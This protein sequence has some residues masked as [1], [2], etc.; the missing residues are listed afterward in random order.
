MGSDQLSLLAFSI[1]SRINRIAEALAGIELF[2]R[3]A[4]KAAAEGIADLIKK[5]IPVW[6]G[7]L[8]DSVEVQELSP[9]AYAVGPTL[10]YGP[11]VNF[12]TGPH[13]P[14]MDKITEWGNAHGFDPSAL[15]S[16]IESFGT[17]AHP[18]MET[19]AAE[20]EGMGASLFFDKISFSLVGGPGSFA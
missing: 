18:F 13:L 6:T 7:D 20:A 10:Y 3:E 5:N 19:A 16:H 4:P 15:M 11:Y 2:G 1:T 8:R 14:N 17:A 9:T 12:G